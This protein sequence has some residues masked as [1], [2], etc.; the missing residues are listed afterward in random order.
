LPP[1][2]N[3]AS[4]DILSE[5][6]A[7]PGPNL[8]TGRKYIPTAKTKLKRNQ[9]AQ[10]IRMRKLTPQSMRATRDRRLCDY[11]AAPG[12]LRTNSIA[13]AKMPMVKKPNGRGWPLK[14]D[15]QLIELARATNSLEFL[16]GQIKRSP[17]AVLRRARRLGISIDD[18]ELSDKSK[19][20]DRLR[21]AHFCV[22]SN[23]QDEG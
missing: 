21:A 19:P 8:R 6:C 4:R 20:S 22:C 11:L 9:L 14:Y 3:F 12:S 16:A 7:E 5:D 17:A 18:S 15:R 2:E 13:K 10:Y 23:P 1:T